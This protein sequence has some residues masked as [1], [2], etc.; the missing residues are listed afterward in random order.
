VAVSVLNPLTTD[1]LRALVVVGSRSQYFEEWGPPD[2]TAP[3]ALLFVAMLVM[4]I[5]STLRSRSSSWAET[6]LL[7]LALGW[8]V[9]SMRTTPVGA[10]LLAPFLATALQSLLPYDVPRLGRERVVLLALLL[11]GTGAMAF[12]AHHRAATEVMPGWVDHR[13]DAVPSGTRVLNEWSPGAYLA[14]RHPDLNLVMNGYGEVF[15]DSEIERNADISRLEPGW[16]RLVSELDVDLAL[17]S[18]DSTLGYALI[19]SDG[20]ELLHE[21]DGYALLE[22]RPESH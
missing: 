15:T 13:L 17:V 2:F 8:G 16:D 9:Y 14:W 10:I 7:V 3:F 11:C 22:P 20:W 4:V 19:E 6:A 21:E 5:I 1:T 12:V 18:P